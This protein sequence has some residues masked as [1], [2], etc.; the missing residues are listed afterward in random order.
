MRWQAGSAIGLL[1]PRHRPETATATSSAAY[2]LAAHQ[3]ALRAKERALANGSIF[4][5]TQRPRL[6][7]FVT[8]SGFLSF[9]D[10]SDDDDCADVDVDAAAASDGAIDVQAKRPRLAT[11]NQHDKRTVDGTNAA[12]QRNGFANNGAAD[13]SN[14]VLDAPAVRSIGSCSARSSR[15][16]I[17]PCPQYQRMHKRAV[18]SDAV[19]QQQHDTFVDDNDNDDDDDEESDGDSFLAY[20]LTYT[21]RNANS[22]THTSRPQLTNNISSPNPGH[23]SSSNSNKSNLSS[24]RRAKRLSIRLSI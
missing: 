24:E 12:L 15:L 22:S 16:F 8:A 1:E 7:Q 3:A 19:C 14:N 17:A 2:T 10:D 9:D 6:A 18:R 5:A 21:P 4:E 23:N 13:N 20:G 11:G